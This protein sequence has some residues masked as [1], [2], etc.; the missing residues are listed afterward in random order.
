MDKHRLEKS[1]LVRACERWPGFSS[2]ALRYRWQNRVLDQGRKGPEPKLTLQGEEA[3][4][5]YLKMQQDVG[6][7]VLAK[8]L[9]EQARKWGMDL[10]IYSGV[11]GRKWLQ[12]YFVRHPELSRRQAQLVE[13]CRL[14]GMNPP[15]VGRFFEIAAYALGMNMP[16][17]ERVPAERTYVIDEAGCDA[18]LAQQIQSVRQLPILACPHTL[19]TLSTHFLQVVARRGPQPVYRPAS[20]VSSHITLVGCVSAAGEV[21]C[22]TLIFQGERCRAKW[23]EGWPEARATANTSGYMTAELFEEWAA[24]FVEASGAT[25]DGLRRVLFL[26]NH[27]SH[28]SV[29]ARQLFKQ[30]NVQLVALHPHTTHVFCVLDVAIF[31]T[32]KRKLYSIY[33]RE[34]VPGVA[35]TREQMSGWMRRA[36]KKATKIRTDKK[37]GERFS[38]AVAG[39]AK[40][41]LVPFQPKLAEDVVFAHHNE[42][43]KQKQAAEVA[44][45]GVAVLEEPS[46]YGMSAAERERLIAGLIEDG[47]LAVKLAADKKKEG[48]KPRP[49]VMSQLLTSSERLEMDEAKDEAKEAEQARKEE[50]RQQRKAARDARG[51]LSASEFKKKVAAEKRAQREESAAA[52]AAAAAVAAAAAAAAQP[53]P[54]KARVKGGA[55]KVAAPKAGP[56]ANAYAKAYAAPARAGGKRA[57][58]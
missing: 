38:P 53:A 56:D 17:E 8:H 10:G 21:L 16:K 9:G 13:A 12:A 28:L 27:S 41:G 50:G 43:I 7:C 40:V 33:C 19:L 46:I 48:Y 42:W 6:N 57:R 51:G 14:T 29:K 36:Y 52:A 2:K 3:F 32:F 44:A 55:A 20:A 35:V 37:T 26:D 1:F 24:W 15:A 58:D 49:V 25:S 30:H 47:K 11:G 54:K 39:F 18:G 45:E 31:A 23:S 22:P 5:E 34:A 4:T